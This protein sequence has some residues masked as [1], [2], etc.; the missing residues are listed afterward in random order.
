MLSFSCSLV[1]SKISSSSRR[2]RKK[3]DQPKAP[4][5]GDP[6][7]QP[8]RARAFAFLSELRRPATIEEIAEHLE[9]HPTGVCTHLARLEEAGLL[10]R[11]TVRSG[12]G[13]P[14]YEWCIAPNAMPQG[15][16]PDAYAELSNWLAGALVAGATSPEE[17]EDHG[18]AIGRALAPATPREPPAQ[19]LD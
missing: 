15:Q 3:M 12:R 13:R 1:G 2:P 19:A 7:A 11:Q 6:L 16:P 18:Y 8:V 5:P 10:N 17:L 14:H 4:A 9:L